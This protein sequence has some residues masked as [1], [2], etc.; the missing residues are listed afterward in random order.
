MLLALQTPQNAKMP[1]TKPTLSAMTHEQLQTAL[2]AAQE[3]KKTKWHITCA[4]CKSPAIVSRRSAIYC[5]T[6]CRYNAYQERF[7]VE[8]IKSEVQNRDL[9]REIEQLKARI[10]E[11]E[12]EAATLRRD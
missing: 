12:T 6:A 5:S 2:E 9:E 11:L 10:R 8:A 3:A 4:R 7:R 1:F